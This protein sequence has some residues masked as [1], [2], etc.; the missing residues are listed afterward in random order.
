MAHEMVGACLTAG[1]L[2]S[3][4]A[5]QAAAEPLRSLGVRHA[6]AHGVPA[7]LADAL[8]RAESNYRPN[9]R[10]GGNLGLTQIS[11]ATARRL[12]YSGTPAGLFEP[13]TNLRYSMKYL[14]QAYRLAGGDTCGTILRYNAGLDR[15]AMTAK[16]RAYCLSRSRLPHDPAFPLA[17]WRAAPVSLF[18][19]GVMSV[20]LA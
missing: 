15:S 20:A 7:D 13:D 4:L 8:V 5:A 9:A 19:F 3:L 10:S 18:H 16:A 1:M 2:C 17:S 12:G 6:A 11:H 14:A